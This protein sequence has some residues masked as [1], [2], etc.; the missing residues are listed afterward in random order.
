MSIT[1]TQRALT[2]D[3]LN[4][5]TGTVFVQDA[6]APSSGQFL[7]ITGT[8]PRGNKKASWATL[9]I[10]DVTGLQTAIDAAETD[11]AAAS[12]ILA[13]A[14]A[15][16]NLIQ[17]TAT[18]AKNL[19]LKEIASQT[20]NILEAQESNGTAFLTMFSGAA[21]ADRIKI[22]GRGE[23]D[24]L[25][26]DAALSATGVRVTGAI[27]TAGSFSGVIGLD[28]IG[29]SSFGIRGRSTSGES[30]FFQS[31]SASNTVGTLV[32]KVNSSSTARLFE[33]QGSSGSLLTYLSFLGGLTVNDQ[34]SDT[35]TRI[36]GDTKANLF[37]LDASVDR[38]GIDQ[39][40]P[41]SRLHLGGSFALPVVTKTTTYTATE[42]DCVI[43]GDA[44]GG[45]FTITL[46]TAVGITGRLY[47]LKKT[48]PISP[49]ST[50]TVDASGTETIDG[51]L[52]QVLNIQF[53][54]I[55]I[56]SDG[57]NWLIL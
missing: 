23:S 5:G 18:T 21:P 19:L 20:G 33:A 24:V 28:A 36:E 51:A 2:T 45:S 14:T 55:T 44:T 42:A 6:S 25:D 34:G 39:A 52:T 29:S 35:D 50:V 57:A 54:S 15:T 46:P 40:V 9:A 43:F 30:G 37:F 3:G 27:S 31:N 7:K 56:V 8:D 38:I 10:S 22:V 41:T 47:Y 12:V 1:Q 32:T 4:H 26:I 48:A 53:E 49:A 13:P 17:P 16:R 11:A